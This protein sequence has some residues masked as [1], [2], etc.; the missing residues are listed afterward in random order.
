MELNT[1]ELKMDKLYKEVQLS[2]KLEKIF[3]I[4]WIV[5]CILLFLIHLFFP[6]FLP[7]PWFNGFEIGYTV[8]M[9]LFLFC[10][11]LKRVELNWK[12]GE[13]YTKYCQ[14]VDDSSDKE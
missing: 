3:G 5:G 14:A 6:H 4:T 2:T 11:W 8:I 12:Y 10:N 7:S 1:F 9:V 13:V